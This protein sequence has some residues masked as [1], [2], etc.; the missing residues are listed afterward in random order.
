[1]EERGYTEEE[2]D[3][4]VGEIRKQIQDKQVRLL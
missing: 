4:K 3:A 1:M 2:V